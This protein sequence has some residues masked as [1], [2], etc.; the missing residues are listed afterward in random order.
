MRLVPSLLIGVALM[1]SLGGCVVASPNAQESTTPTPAASS[2]FVSD[3]GASRAADQAFQ[4]FLDATNAVATDPTVDVET[5]RTVA[6]GVAAENEIA[7]N[8]E[9]R[10]RGELETGG[11]TFDSP[12]YEQRWTDDGAERV[13]AYYCIDLSQTHS[14][15]A[16]GNDVTST[17][18]DDRLELQIVFVTDSNN[19][20][21]LLVERTELWDSVGRC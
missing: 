13:V 3:E 17:G 15:D 14:F 20:G 4:R 8:Q 19:P 1:L 10:D 21:T 11:V 12:R 16:S 9:A 7:S 6:T 5:I 2:H 18:R